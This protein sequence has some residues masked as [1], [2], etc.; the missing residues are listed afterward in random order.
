MQVELA[1][2][3]AGCQIQTLLQPILDC[4]QQAALG[5]EALSSYNFV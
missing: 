4:Q 3:L 2:I 5:Y 1:R